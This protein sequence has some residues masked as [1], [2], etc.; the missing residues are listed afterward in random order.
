MEYKFERK[1]GEKHIDNFVSS[2]YD[3]YRKI[4]A[5]NYIF[6]LE[7]VEWISN[8]GLL[9]FTSIL[10]YL[11]NKRISFKVIFTGLNDETN[12]RKI[13]QVCELWYVWKIGKIIEN[14]QEWKH[15]FEFA[16]SRIEFS[17]TLLDEYLRKFNIKTDNNL[18][19]RL[20][21]TPFVE[22]N[23]I[24]N[25]ND[26]KILEDVINPI[27]SLNEVIRK[28]L[29]ENDSEHPFINNTISYIIT[30]EL[31][32]N[33]LDHFGKSFFDTTHNWCFL[34]IALRRK[35]KFFSNDL[36][37]KNFKEEELDDTRYFFVND[38]KYKNQS[39]IEFSFLDFGQ[40]IVESLIS[41]YRKEG[42]DNENPS[43]ILEYAFKYDTSCNPIKK[44]DNDSFYIPRGLF[45]I[46]TIVKRYRGLI[47]VRSNSSRIIYDYSK[48]ENYDGDL[49]IKTETNFFPGTFITIYIPA[50]ENKFIFDSSVIRPIS[51]VQ[52]SKNF[53]INFVSLNKIFNNVNKSYNKDYS[54]LIKSLAEELKNNSQ[55]PK[56][57]II[58]FL[59]CNNKNFIQKSIFFFLTT[60]DINLNNN[61]VVIHPPEKNVLE[62]I[63]G[64]LSNLNEVIIN[65][66]INPIPF[67]YDTEDAI[68]ENIY[69]IGLSDDADKKKLN[70]FIFEDVILPTSD[71]NDPNSVLGNLQYLKD[72][73]NI[74]SKIPDINSIQSFESM[75]IEE[76]IKRNDCIRKD[77]LYLCNGNYYQEE[78]LQLLE[79]LNNED[80]CEIIT[81]L[82]HQKIGKIDSDIKFIAITSSSHKILNSLIKQNL[83][84]V[85]KCIFLD[86]YVNFHKDPNIELITRENRYYLFGD[87]ISGGSMVKRLDNIIRTKNASLEKLIFLV[88]TVDE[89]FENSQVFLN[90]NKERIIYAYRYK[91]KKF[92]KDKIVQK[93]KFNSL[94]RIN[95][96]TNLPILFSEKNTVTDSILL[97]NQPFLD[98]I[99]DEDI[100]INFRIFNNNIHPYFF[101]LKKILQEQNKKIKN[102]EKNLIGDLIKRLNITINS[103]LE[104]FYPKNSDIE[105]IDFDIFKSNILKNHSIEFYSLDRFSINAGWKYPHTTDRYEQIVKNKNLLI[106]DD[107]S[108]S[109][110]SILQMINELSH[111]EPEQITLLCLVGKI[112]SHKREFYSRIKSMKHKSDKDDEVLVNIYFGCNWNLPYFN[113]NGSPYSEE[114]NWL[115]E[116]KKIKYLPQS[117]K[118]INNLVLDTVIPKNNNNNDYK[119]FIKDKQ[120]RFLKKEL[121]LIRNEIGKIIG[122]RFYLESFSWFNSF[123]AKYEQRQKEVGSNDRT[124]DIELLCMCLLYEPYIYKRM[125]SIMPDIKEKIEEF[126]QKILIG[127]EIKIE[128]E[129]LYFD[130]K[131]NIKDLI[132][133]F[134]IVFD[135]ENIIRI[136]NLQGLN[137]F[138]NFIIQHD[139]NIST[140]NYLFFKIIYYY[141]LTNE[142]VSQK[143]YTAHFTNTISALIES[144]NHSEDILKHI[145]RFKSFIST[146]PTSDDFTSRK[147]EIKE[148]YRTIKDNAN[149]RDSITAIYDSLIIKL[150]V[151]K[152]DPT[153]LDNVK[154][155]WHKVNTFMEKFISFEKTFPYFFLDDLNISEKN[156]IQSIQNEISDIFLDDINIQAST[157]IV[158]EKL[159]S[160][161]K[162][163]LK[164][165]SAIFYKIFNSTKTDVS[166]NKIIDI[167][168][169][170]CSELLISIEINFEV[171]NRG[172][173]ALDFP[174]YYFNTYIV[175]EICKNFRHSKGA[176][177]IKTSIK[178]DKFIMEVTNEKSQV[179]TDGG[180]NGLLKLENL[181]H[182]P[183]EIV[184]Y[185][186]K[187]ENRNFVQ[188]LIITTI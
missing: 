145:K 78:F 61:I 21:I 164:S 116:I 159:N 163:Y 185:I 63:E 68:K 112:T 89:E 54:L 166:N 160:F 5:D 1:F 22:L 41:Q 8:Q 138:I 118:K 12:S 94:I 174:E 183:D 75:L 96:Y 34:S 26:K 45:D 177:D 80:D 124:K 106:I 18:F 181:K 55:E 149:H 101:D 30:R 11:Y 168:K 72:N 162:N 108:S 88:N 126:V 73:K 140:I 46:L 107:G 167:I 120:G 37:D 93:E 136:L 104:I 15:Y 134:F 31:Y 70:E 186:H 65:F 147:N 123:M 51:H 36:L 98:Y 57:N 179:S 19:N 28:E 69:W 83:I 109:G 156:S 90:E 178:E 85:E 142:E 71:F 99:E 95:P 115:K 173:I 23:F 125:A 38:H 131:D 29:K 82:L 24:D 50:L 44:I 40:G 152:L 16:N 2:F 113:I 158:E 91:I 87:V 102:D 81:N 4:P 20:G 117:L 114:I 77:G 62:S 133:L 43:D 92:R 74:Y 14:V 64:E 42:Y 128:L 66:K 129:Y 25:Y 48:S 146:L 169:N 3:N 184:Q 60:Y 33:F 130:W 49:I 165:E 111:F 143:K 35:T 13:Q 6:N 10:K 151:L 148:Y 154:N 170:K 79:L 172:D 150:K 110:D 141:P 100:I 155:D 32:E 27:Y 144:K 119:F 76:I 180:G 175:E 97:D 135:N 121:L 7:D 86:S 56:V 67:L 171:V 161:H 122:Y 153:I 39:L 187:D 139:K 137:K 9:L 59:G 127:N 47:I 53:K 105:N 176:V 157:D 188:K 103:N 52:Y 132:H 58:S 84:A 17:N 182:Y